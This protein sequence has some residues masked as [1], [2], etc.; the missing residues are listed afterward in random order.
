MIM[1]VVP[2]ETD[3]QNYELIDGITLTS[4]IFVGRLLMSPMTPGVF[5]SLFIK[6]LPIQALSVLSD[7]LPPWCLNSAPVGQT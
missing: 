1:Q 7:C 4:L 3:I 5:V 2:K 6:V